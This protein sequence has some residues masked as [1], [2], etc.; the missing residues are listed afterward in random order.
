MKAV[1]FKTNY[2]A[3][4]QE[5]MEDSV[6][7]IKKEAVRLVSGPLLKVASGLLI[8]SFHTRVWDN[9]HLGSVWN[10]APYAYTWEATGIQYK[11]NAKSNNKPVAIVKRGA[12]GNRSQIGV[13]FRTLNYKKTKNKRPVHFLWTA[14]KNEMTGSRGQRRFETL[15]YEVGYAVARRYV[16]MLQRRYSS[17]LEIWELH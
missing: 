16:N 9:G 10:D 13:K 12:L 6:Q 5:W 4:F 3:I 11:L 2:V 7:D 1:S 8:R 14:T 15:G 17:V